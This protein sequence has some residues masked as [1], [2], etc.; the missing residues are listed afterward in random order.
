MSVQ[1]DLQGE[2]SFEASCRF[3]EG[4]AMLIE[5]APAARASR[6]TPPDP[7]ERAREDEPADA[8]RE[9]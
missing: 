1:K 7:P 3:R 4:A 2:G 9:R 5:S 8:E 6:K